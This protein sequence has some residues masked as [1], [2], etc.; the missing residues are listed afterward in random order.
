[1][2]PRI[3]F[4]VKRRPPTDYGYGNFGLKTSAEMCAQTLE[5]YGFSTRLVEVQDNNAIDFHLFSYKPDICIIEA[6]WVVPEKIEI[7]AKLHPKVSFFIRSHSNVEFISFE[8]SAIGWLKAYQKLG[9]KYNVVLAGNSSRFCHEMGLV[10]L[11]VVYMPNIY[12]DIAIPSW[13]IKE[14]GKIRIGQWG[15]WR[16]MKNNL[17]QAVAAIAF[18]EKI[19]KTLEYHINGTRVEQKA[20]PILKNVRALFENSRHTLVEHPWY[21]HSKFL[22]EIGKVDLTLQVSFSETFNIVAA[23]SVAMKVPVIGSHQI[24]WLPFTAKAD[25]NSVDSIVRKLSWAYNFPS[26]LAGLNSLYLED[27]NRE[28]T[29][30]WLNLLS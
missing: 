5:D 30:V 15:A 14:K 4:V 24:D 8:G 27:Y 12:R 2:L 11:D 29:S 10:G 25:P 20:E 6:L 19:G 17:L 18:A 3:L 21:T 1:M 28:A 9:E 22:Y 7:L 26:L 23:D 16:P 13:N